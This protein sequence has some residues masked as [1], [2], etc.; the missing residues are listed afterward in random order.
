ME[1]YTVRTIINEIDNYIQHLMSECGLHISLHPQLQES[2]IMHSKLRIYN[3]HQ[4]SY[5]V[6]LKS[7]DGVH[8]ECVNCQKKAFHK[9]QNG[10]F[11]G[12]CHAGVMEYVYPIICGETAIGFISVSG[13]SIPNALS[14]H[15]L[16]SEKFA[17]ELDVLTDMY[18]TLTATLPPKQDIDTLINPLQR[19]LELAYLKA[20]SEAKAQNFHHKV[21][22]FI[23]EH[24][25]ENLTSEDIC[26]HFS[27]SRSYLSH[28][29]K[30]NCGMSIREYMNTLRI[31]D[32]KT[33]L[34]CSRLNVTEIS[35]V[36]GFS[37]SNYF[38]KLF[39]KTVGISPGRYRKEHIEA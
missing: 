19:M 28:M 36:L 34:T 8:Q 25:T 30:K 5:C 29:F 2:V 6:F 9:C 22:N 26:K 27:C 10:S 33:L 21:L 39:K 4:N 7:I 23:K 20:P 38:S 15:R 32:A 35:I 13:Y 31:E 18:Q 14:Y 17:I 24:H 3:I 37:D 11:C 16:L 1:E 12:V